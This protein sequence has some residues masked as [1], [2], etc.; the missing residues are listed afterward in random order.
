MKS[1]EMLRII[2][3]ATIVTAN[4][5]GIPHLEDE[6]TPRGNRQQGCRR[7]NEHVCMRCSYQQDGTPVP[8]YFCATIADGCPAEVC[9]D[10][11]TE[12]TCYDE[13][14]KDPISCARY[15]EGGCPCPS[16]QVKCGV[17]HF[18]S[19]YCT[20][21][22]CDWRVE[23]TCHN[24]NGKP[25]SCRKYD[26]GPCPSPKK[27]NRQKK[28]RPPRP[29]WRKKHRPRRPSQNPNKSNSLND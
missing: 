5:A 18:S 14:T 6:I 12:E 27:P 24:G 22:C 11:K 15:D 29:N 17:S 10:I 21:L 25:I 4:D 9:C 20:A 2:L 16:S 19:G 26:D 8:E 23:Q 1:V 3:L 28:H 13:T 7:R